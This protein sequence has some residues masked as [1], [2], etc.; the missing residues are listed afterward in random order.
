[1]KE[2]TSFKQKKSYITPQFT[3]IV[4]DNEISLQ[5]ESAP[6]VGPNEVRFNQPES[7]MS[8]SFKNLKV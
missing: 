1:M 7:N 3:L 4:L 6:P 5:L 2:N 8:D